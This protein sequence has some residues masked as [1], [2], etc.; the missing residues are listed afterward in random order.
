MLLQDAKEAKR[1]ATTKLKKLEKDI[2]ALTK[3]IESL[4]LLKGLTRLLM[5]E[6]AIAEAD[7]CRGDTWLKKITL[8]TIIAKAED[9]L[10]PPSLA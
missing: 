9:C 7:N 8:H 5:T 3:A 2:D 4:Q 1:R 10:A 6:K